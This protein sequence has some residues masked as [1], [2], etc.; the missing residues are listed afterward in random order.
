MPDG[1]TPKVSL[2]PR[3]SLLAVGLLLFASA[4]A[5][6]AG[7]R[8]GVAKFEGAQEA[9]VRKKVMQS[10]K[11]HGFELVRSREIQDAV[12]STGASLDSD[13]G[14]VA[15]SKELALSVIVTGEVGPKRAKIVLHDGGEGSIL[16]D[17][18]FSGANPRKLANEVGLTFWKKLGPD[19]GRGH[20]PTGAKKGQ[21]AAAASPEDDENSEGEGAAAGEAATPKPKDDSSA[22]AEG[23]GSDEAPPPPKKKKTKPKMEE[24]PPPEESAPSVPS[25]LAWLDFELGVGG[26]NRSLTFNQNIVIGNSLM[27]LP[28]SLGVGPIA[29]ANVVM[30][31]LD[32]L[33]GGPIGNLGL[34]AEIQQ[35]F[36]ISSS[37]SSGGSF[38]D[39]V[40]DYAG[41]L[42]YRLIFAGGDDVYL[43]A[44]AGEDAFT[45]TGNTTARAQLN[46]PDTIYHYFRPGIGLNLK[47]ADG[48]TVRLGAGYRYVYNDG[49]PQIS[50][51][52][53]FP[54]L[55]VA[56]ADADVVVGYALSEM[57]EARAGLEWRR[58]WYAM[59]SQ[60]TDNAIAGGAV[61]QSFA[62]TLRIAILIGSSSVPKAEG[63][64]EEAPPPPPPKPKSR[65]RHHDDEE[66]GDSDSEGAPPA[67]SDSGHKSGGDSDE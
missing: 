45:F 7:K 17:A 6:A 29:T 36:A 65:S 20:V 64:A 11:S 62:F 31:P 49:G 53:F 12:S 24:A 1:L 52:H 16:G 58:Y 26:L 66:S 25:G 8:I 21:K 23:D 67:D 10:L 15:V 42:R 47:V 56:G 30:Y 43:S 57:F 46:I 32:P 9:L 38:K 41:G 54:H 39:V 63:G 22:S 37:L 60:A 55:T 51:A 34:E 59:H 13:D 18:S 61:D 19:V 27:M 33:I 44:T 5:E 2:T 4:S 40:H 3:V 14:I 35:G 28:Y 48:L 50:S